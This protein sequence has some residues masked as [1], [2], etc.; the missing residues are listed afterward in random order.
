MA[1]A[2]RD[3]QGLAASPQSTSCGWWGGPRWSVRADD[4]GP[5]AASAGPPRAHDEGSAAVDQRAAAPQMLPAARVEFLT[6]QLRSRSGQVGQSLAGPGR[7]RHL[8][9]PE[10]I[11]RLDAGGL[12]EPMALQVDV[13][14]LAHGMRKVA[15]RIGGAMVFMRGARELLGDKRVDE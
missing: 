15:H 3:C 9:R 10:V 8:Q 6:Q 1:Y 7:Q 5:W 2:A 11:D 14:S 12:T 4:L 13:S